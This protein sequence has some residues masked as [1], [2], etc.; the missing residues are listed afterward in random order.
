MR[1]VG[2]DRA[3]SP[4][5]SQPRYIYCAIATTIISARIVEQT[6][7]PKMEK[8][9]IFCLCMS[10]AAA[11]P[12]TVLPQATSYIYRNDNNGPA[13]LITL[14]DAHVQQ[15]LIWNPVTA[16]PQPAIPFEPKHLPFVVKPVSEEKDDEPAILT[17]EILEEDSDEDYDDGSSESGESDYLE[18]HEAENGEKGSKGHEA[19]EEHDEAD[20]EQYGKQHDEGYYNE[21]EDKKENSFDES[22]NHGQH[23]EEGDELDG[24]NQGHKKHFSKGVD[25]TGYHKVFHKDEYKKDH[26]F[27]DEADNSGNFHKHGY[28]KEHHG[29]AKGGHKLA[30]KHDAGKEFSE[31]GKAGH[32]AKGHHDINHKEHHAEDGHDDVYS[33]EEDDAEG[34]EFKSQRSHAYDED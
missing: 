14:G 28:A 23:F 7:P 16:P 3:L 25:V 17:G 30:E 22:D 2:S 1:K 21:D 11:L 27:Y 19:H 13:S 9:I 29:A 6:S 10:A 24:E 33:E 26:D 31:F 18:E 4:L 8:T 34:K 12:Y 32:L 5:L 20:A 15:P